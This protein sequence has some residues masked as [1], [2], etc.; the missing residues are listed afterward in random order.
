MDS[1]YLAPPKCGKMHLISPPGSPP[2]GWEQIDESHPNPDPLADDLHADAFVLS[3]D[4]T[5][6]RGPRPSDQEASRALLA[7]VSAKLASLSALTA[8]KSKPPLIALFGDGDHD[9]GDE[10][11]S[12]LHEEN[13]GGDITRSSVTGPRIALAQAS[14][15][16]G[17]APTTGMGQVTLIVP[18]Y[19]DTKRTPV[20]APTLNI[21]HGFIPPVIVV[22][23]H[24]GDDDDADF[25]AQPT[26]PP[27]RP[28]IPQTRMPPRS[29]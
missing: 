7:S 27:A 11:G 3:R 12:A 5:V 2:L 1:R 20:F 10:D 6:P 19:S 26:L 9:N 16:G 15:G 17:E 25:Q 22:E 24:G 18:G 4:P 21:A 29:V 23:D 28:T 8:V 13:H 14:G